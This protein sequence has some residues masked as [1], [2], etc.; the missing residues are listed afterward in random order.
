MTLSIRWKVAIGSLLA[1]AC[2]LAVAGL[3]AV[4]SLERQEIT[5]LG[6]MLEARTTLV[7]YG[8][9]RTL[10]HTAPALDAVLT[11]NTVRELSAKTATRITLIG[12]DG[13]V[14]ADSAVADPD[15]PA[16][17]NH[18]SRPEIQQALTAG[19]GTDV[20][21]SRTTGIRTMYRAVT[22]ELR[23]NGKPVFLRLGLPMTLLDQETAKLQQHLAI[24]FGVAFLVAVLISL[25]LAR[26]I[27]KPLSEIAA[28]L[29]RLETIRKDF[30]ANVSHELRTP[31]TSI[32]GYVEALL[33]G[34]KDDPGT[35]T[36]FLGII[37]KQTDRLNLILEDL[38]ELSKIESEIGRAH[39]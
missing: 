35:A 1:V 39:V 32:K 12:A 27:T 6:T 38:L 29:R 34:G 9:T 23:H 28:E 2:G 30:V 7:A 37:L 25:W 22:T 18:L 10:Q 31:L 3:L 8:L 5:Q 13:L 14:L 16:V 19:Q 26:S 4:Q 20:R 36:Q 11:R 21:V 15:L 24:A 33:D 17:D